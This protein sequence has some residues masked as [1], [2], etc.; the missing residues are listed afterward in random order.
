MHE[1]PVITEHFIERASARSSW[2]L[3]LELLFAAL[4][5]A[6]VA[7]R[8]NNLKQL[9]NHH[10]EQAI[11]LVTP[12]YSKNRKSVVIVIGNNKL[13]T[14]YKVHEAAWAISWLTKTPIKD[15]VLFRDSHH[16]K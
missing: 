15:R 7:K 2:L 5:D 16:V 13:K 8:D 12:R 1:I 11:Y 6:W 3:D 10:C 9:L 4:N 14:C